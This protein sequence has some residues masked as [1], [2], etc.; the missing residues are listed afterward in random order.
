MVDLKSLIHKV[1]VDPKLLHSK[2]CL[3][4]NQKQHDPEENPVVF[5]ELTIRFRLFFAG[6]RTITSQEFLKLM[7]ERLLFGH[8]ASTK[9][10]A[11]SSNFCWSGMEKDSK[12][13]VFAQH[14]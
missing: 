14:A 4:N 8:T 11:A 12:N 6:D 10:I 13:A 7:S 3:Q 2:P 1:S 9:K 5:I